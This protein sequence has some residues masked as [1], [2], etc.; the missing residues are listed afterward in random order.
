MLLQE[1]AKRLVSFPIPSFCGLSFL[2]PG[3]GDGVE[4]SGEDRH[5]LRQTMRYVA[6][7]LLGNA[8][9]TYSQ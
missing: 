8:I 7:E 3:R 1:N 2:F 9:S 6:N 4:R 5:H